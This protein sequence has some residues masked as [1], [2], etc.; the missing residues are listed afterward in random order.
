MGVRNGIKYKKLEVDK[1]A[2]ELSDLTGES[3]TEVIRRALLELKVSMSFRVAKID[4]RTR[5][6]E[7]LEKEVW[8]KLPKKVLGKKISTKEMDTILG[9]GNGEYDS[10]YVCYHIDFFKG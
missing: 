4:R 8:A 2:T 3:K 9:Y 5:M 6:Q 7:F 1:L 10:R